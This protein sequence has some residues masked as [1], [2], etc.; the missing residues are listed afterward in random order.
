MQTA[1]HT[2][3]SFKSYIDDQAYAGRSLFFRGQ[4]NDSWGLVSTYHRLVN[5]GE[6]AAYWRLLH[7][8]HDYISTWSGHTWNLENDKDVA[9][10]LGFLQ[11][12][13]FPT[14]L[15][16]WTRSPYAA[17]YFAFDGVNDSTPG[18]DYVAVFAFDPFAWSADWTQIYNVQH[19]GAHVSVLQN[20]SRGNHKQLLQQ[21]A[22]TFSTVR[23][24]ASHIAACEQKFSIDNG[25]GKT[26]LAKHLISVHE[27]PAVMRDL[28]LMGI[29][30]MTLFPGIEGVCRHLA[31]ALFPAPKLG[32]SPT[33]RTEAFLEFLNRQQ[34][35]RQS[36]GT[37]P[38]L[39]PF[40]PSNFGDQTDAG[41]LDA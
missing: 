19:K 22:Y 3:K 29:S 35:E 24:Q 36:T 25:E 31:N 8:V 14:P 4:S 7:L 11:H 38:L 20:N 6:P 5:P 34:A 2:W 23:D 18:S 15:L 16:D 32:L 27:K 13:G 41:D 39:G 1:K 10:F 40:E 30:A 26:Y 28:G 12:N 21:G 17:A 9:S 37:N 33:Q